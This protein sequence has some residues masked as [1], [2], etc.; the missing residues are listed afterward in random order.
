MATV[1]EHQSDGTYDRTNEYEVDEF[2]IDQA[3]YIL[4]SKD[5]LCGGECRIS[6]EPVTGYG[7]GAVLIEREM[8]DED[9]APLGDGEYEPFIIIA[10]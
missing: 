4:C 10:E 1:Y 8:V 3:V 5:V 9:G 2:S 6:K 7:E